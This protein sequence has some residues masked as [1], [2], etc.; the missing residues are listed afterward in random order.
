MKYK[1]SDILGYTKSGNLPMVHNLLR[2]HKIGQ[3]LIHL[4]GCTDE[5]AMTKIE[6]VKMDEWNPLL[7]AIAFKKL[8]V[9]RYFL[10]D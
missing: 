3:N 9:V 1:P 2:Y 6:K 4:K 10:E 8:D 7:V 5:F